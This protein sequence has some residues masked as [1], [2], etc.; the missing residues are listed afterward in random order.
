[1]NDLS[2]YFERFDPIMRKTNLTN[3][4]YYVFLKFYNKKNHRKQKKVYICILTIILCH[5]YIQPYY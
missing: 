1:M 5:E 2:W 4:Y 3:K